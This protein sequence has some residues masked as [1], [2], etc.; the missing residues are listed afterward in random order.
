MLD[1]ITVEKELRGSFKRIVLRIPK[2]LQKNR[3]I[4]ETAIVYLKLGGEK[5]AR[6]AIEI[7]KTANDLE[8]AQRKRKLRD[9]ALLRAAEARKIK[10][11]HA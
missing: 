8:A 9:E 2:K 11:I 7:F 1:E 5:L 4:L 10:K 3:Y 6:Q